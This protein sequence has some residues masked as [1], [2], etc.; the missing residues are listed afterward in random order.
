[1]ITHPEF[2][3]LLSAAIRVAKPFH[4]EAI[5]DIDNIDMPFVDMVI[6]SLDMLMICIYLS[7]TYGVP[8][9]IAK[10]MKPT[11][12]REMLEFLLEHK[13]REVTDVD[14]AIAE[15]K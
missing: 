15:L 11:T 9:E 5:Q 1:M 2:L 4:S 8:E 12:P 7:E 10:E 3:R 6:D 13:T 14:K